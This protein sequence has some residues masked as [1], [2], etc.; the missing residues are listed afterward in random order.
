M[1][2]PQ[3]ILHFIFPNGVLGSVSQIVRFLLT[4]LYNRH[5]TLDQT[6]IQTLLIT[7][8]ELEGGLT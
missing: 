8:G 6:E 1:A 5:L 2:R 7:P 4:I 3:V